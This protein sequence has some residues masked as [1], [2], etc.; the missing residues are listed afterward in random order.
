MAFEIWT[1]LP[2]RLVF[3][4][5]YLTD[6]QY[7]ISVLIYTVHANLIFFHLFSPNFTSAL[8]T[9]TNHYA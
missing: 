2:L 3:H 8:V 5:F 9:F 7:F 6:L 4:H 1:M